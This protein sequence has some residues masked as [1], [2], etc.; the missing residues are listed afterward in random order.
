MKTKILFISMYGIEN[1]AARL[2]SAILKK[3]N[4]DTET[5]FFK[6][7]KNNNIKEPTSLEFNLLFGEIARIK[8]DIIGISFRSPYFNIV[9]NIS[10]RIKQD[11]VALIKG[12]IKAV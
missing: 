10:R 5:I 6:N 12:I 3:N 4:Y 8:P 2:L 1:N 7:W 11:I 9:K